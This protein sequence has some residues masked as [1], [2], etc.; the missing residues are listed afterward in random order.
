MEFA[1]LTPVFLALIT[2]IME[3]AM[4]LFVAA[5]MEGGLRDASRFGITGFEP[6]GKTREERILEIVGNN[7]IGL[8]DMS[9]ATVQSLIYPSFGDIGGAE[10]FVDADPANG[11]Y[12]SGETFTDVNGNGSWDPD[13]GAAGTGGP[14]DVVVYR[15][16]YDWPL[17]TPILAGVIGEDGKLRLGA[18]VIVRNE[19]YESAAGGALP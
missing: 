16:S 4:I 3:L 8:V 1:L 12:D 9:S 19:P 18:S 2:G 15:L 5:L 6:E 13:M 11:S 7:T 10:P 14:G 17:L